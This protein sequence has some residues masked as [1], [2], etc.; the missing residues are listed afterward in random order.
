MCF[1]KVKTIL[2]ISQEWLVR[3]MWNEKEVHRLD[4]GYNMGTWPMTLTLDVSRSNFEIALSLELLVWLMWN[5]NKGELI[6][7]CA[8]CMTLP[9]DHTHD[10]DLGVEISRSESEITVIHSWAWY[11][12]TVVWPWWGGRMYWIVTGVTSDVG[13]PSTYLVVQSFWN[14]AQSTAMVQPCS[15]QNFKTFGNLVWLLWT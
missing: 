7:Y 5:E 11:W 1:F 14:F 13:V 8:D 12:L 6:W 15:V 4:T 10:L 2:A 9:F 3:S